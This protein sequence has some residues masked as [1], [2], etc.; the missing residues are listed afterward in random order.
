MIDQLKNARAREWIRA[1]EQ[2]G[3]RTRKRKGR[4]TY[5]SIPMAAGCLWFITISGTRSA[6]KQSVN[7]WTA[8]YGGIKTC[9]G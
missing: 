7:C 4:I 8:H 6:Q 9:A 1:L 2:E 5:I 3:F